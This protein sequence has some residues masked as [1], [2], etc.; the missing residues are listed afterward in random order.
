MTV[1]IK[2]DGGSEDFNRDKIRRAIESAARRTKL[3]QKRAREVAE[4]VAKR[5]EEHFS[6]EE[7]VRSTDIRNRVLNELEREEKSVAREFKVFRKD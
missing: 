4:K 2:K 6:R 7:K 5:V 3:E 1:V